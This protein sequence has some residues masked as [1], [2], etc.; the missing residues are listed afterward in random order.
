MRLLANF[1]EIWLCDFEFIADPGER[2]RPICLVARELR[3]NRKLRLWRDQFGSAPPYS[4][5]PDSVFIA[6]FASAELGCHLSLGW[7]MPA[8]ILDLFTE[9]RNLTNGLDTLAGNSLLGALAHHGLDALGVTEKKEMRDLILGGGPWSADQQKAILDYCESDV[10]ALERLLS[11]MLPKIDIPRALY[12]GRY[13]AASARMEAVGIPINVELLAKLRERWTA[14]QDQ[15]IADIDADY[16]IFDGRTFKLDRFENWLARNKIPWPVLESGQLNLEQSTFRDMAKIYPSVSPLHELRHTLSE[17]RLNELAVGADG[18]NRCLLSPFRSKTSRNQPSNTKYIFGPS[19]WLRSLIAPPPGWGVA[20]IDWIQQEFGIAAA[21]SKDPN[22]RA[23]Y[24]TGDAYLAFAKQAGAVPSDATK[25]SHRAQRDQ[26]KQCVLG[27]QYGIGDKSL[28]NRIGQ[29]PIIARHL[30]GLHRSVY[31]EFWKW[32]D[33]CVDHAMFHG[34]QVTVFGWVNRVFSESNPRSIRNFPMQ[35]NG[36]EMLRLA[37]CLGTENG[38]R[39]CAPVH[40]AVLIA[41]PLNELDADVARMRGY[42]EEASRIV[43]AGFKLETEAKT[44]RHPDHYSDQRGEKMFE[45][46][47][48]LL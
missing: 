35:A 39:I 14:I 48:S 33:N 21:L 24:Q 17:M 28:A 40:D 29:L 22:M 36:A 45:K 31:R 9:F 44:V 20:Y 23:A 6:Y 43:L 11:A 4:T 47:L 38:I 18:Y 16:H 12:R 1:N 46:I 34:R 5:A 30:L 41:A 37:C 26:F 15:L 19:V 27:V 42:M 10:D 13:M 3:S 8:R 7:P 32:S 2:P 25:E